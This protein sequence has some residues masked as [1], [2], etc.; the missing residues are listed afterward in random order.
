MTCRVFACSGGCHSHS[1]NLPSRFSVPPPGIT[2]A[3]PTHAFFACSLCISLL[4]ECDLGLRVVIST[5]LFASVH[6]RLSC[7]TVSLFAVYFDRVSSP[8]LVVGQIE[9][10][11]SRLPC[12]R[13]YV[14]W[15]K[16]NRRWKISSASVVNRKRGK[17][18]S[19]GRRTAQQ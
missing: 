1:S 14:P 19:N 8:R 17:Q 12:F 7:N 4:R 5:Y 2:L 6:H 16:Y 11:Y 3:C 13:K 18:D 9:S 15:C 10:V